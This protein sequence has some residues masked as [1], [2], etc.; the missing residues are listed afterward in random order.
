MV[1]NTICQVPLNLDDK[2]A[3]KRFLNQLVQNIDEA[4][5]Y[6]G[7]NQVTSYNPK[8]GAISDLTDSSDIKQVE[9]K[10]N[11]ILSALRASNIISS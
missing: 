3:T 11:E 4:F 5:G 6:R 10:L 7:K 9:E 8:Q 2:T 1:G